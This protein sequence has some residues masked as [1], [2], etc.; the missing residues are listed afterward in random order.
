MV[1][2]RLLRCF[3]SGLVRRRLSF[4][5]CQHRECLA[6]RAFLVLTRR[7]T[8]TFDTDDNDNDDDNERDIAMLTRSV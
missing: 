3:T 5:V 2:P 7:C 4:L 1:S 8:L 6:D